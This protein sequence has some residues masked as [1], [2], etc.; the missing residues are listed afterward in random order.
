VSTISRNEDLGQRKAK[1]LEI[2]LDPEHFDVEAPV[3]H[4]EGVRFF[5][6]ALPEIDADEVDLSRDFLGRRIDLPLFI[7][8]MTGGSEQ[9]FRVNQDLARAAQKARIPVGLG[10]IR[11][12]FRKDEVFEH[13]HLRKLAPDV[14]ILSNLGGVQIRDIPHED[15]HEMN[16]RLEVDAQV[17]HLNPGQELFQPDGDRDF[18]Q[19]YTSIRKFIQGSP[20]PVIVKETGFGISPEE[21]DRL[22]DAG[23]AY[24]DLA[25]S[26]GTNWI[27]V[28][29]YRLEE[30]N[31]A[32][33]EEFR[34]WGYPTPLLLAAVGHHQG[35]IL[36]SGGIRSGMDAAKALALGA[37]AVGM[38]LPFVRAVVQGGPEAVEKLIDDFQQVLR[39]VLVLTG[40]E[41]L[42]DFH[43]V[44]LLLSPEFRSAVDSLRRG[45]DLR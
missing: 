45:G 33:A 19:I 6:K 40:R 36:A 9:G 22:L 24:V 43:R 21:V 18:R 3:N 8:C 38:A 16:R 44:P 26:G 41:S 32:A 28:E 15:I 11:I 10:S 30:E 31:R 4:F 12:L 13:F 20:I 1:H 39:S 42:R 37:Q 23:A 29:S 17:I 2:C 34:D 35:R 27:T 7:S 25:G 5:H 14:P